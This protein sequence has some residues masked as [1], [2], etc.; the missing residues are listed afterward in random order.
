MKPIQ[1][2]LNRIRWD[3]DFGN[4]RF[5]IGYYDRLEDRVILVPFTEVWFSE[6]DHHAFELIDDEG[7]G[8]TIPYHRVRDV[9]RNGKRIWHREQPSA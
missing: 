2:I 9:Y 3:P 4:A 6:E 1:D 7:A 5:E 8:H